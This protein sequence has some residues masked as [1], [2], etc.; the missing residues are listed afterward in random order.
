[1]L[2]SACSLME[3]HEKLLDRDMFIGWVFFALL[4]KVKTNI[5]ARDTIKPAIVYVVN[6]HMNNPPH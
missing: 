3:V 1:M 6:F 4:K 2:R 5:I